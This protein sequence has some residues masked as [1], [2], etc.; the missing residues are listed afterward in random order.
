MKRVRE[1]KNDL[2]LSGDVYPELNQDIQWL[3]CTQMPLPPSFLNWL[4]TCQLVNFQFQFKVP[5]KIRD[6][7]AL[8]EALSHNKTISDVILR[9]GQVPLRRLVE[10][11]Y[12]IG[13]RHRV[14]VQRLL[15]TY[16]VRTRTPIGNQF[17]LLER[18]PAE[19][20]KIKVLIQLCRVLPGDL[21]SLVKEFT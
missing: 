4:K 10:F 11:I 14:D 3:K 12:C 15:H 18:A 5:F 13:P 19:R 21:V 2:E 6:F 17:E 8:E 1:P 9:G 7:D 16:C 20:K